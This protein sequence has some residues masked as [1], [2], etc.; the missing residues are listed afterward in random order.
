MSVNKHLT[1]TQL[2][3]V[4][5]AGI[6]STSKT[7]VAGLGYSILIQL[8]SYENQSRDAGVSKAGRT[9]VYPRHIDVGT[10]AV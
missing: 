5:V 1:K 6:L 7:K 8:R 4:Y 9:L 3:D 10:V 2:R